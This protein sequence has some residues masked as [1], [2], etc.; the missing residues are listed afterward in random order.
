MT[1]SKIGVEGREKWR[2]GTQNGVFQGRSKDENALKYI[3][4]S[5]ATILAKFSYGNI[6][7]QIENIEKT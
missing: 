6:Y 1:F 4:D 3:L 7:F 2:F 5:S